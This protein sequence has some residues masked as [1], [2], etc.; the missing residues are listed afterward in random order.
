MDEA[1]DALAAVDLPDGFSR[2]AAEIYRRLADG[3]LAP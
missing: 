2:A 1:G 3:R